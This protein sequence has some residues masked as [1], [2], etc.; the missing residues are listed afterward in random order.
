M[1]LIFRLPV[2]VLLLLPTLVPTTLVGAYGD[3][4]LVTE[5][6]RLTDAEHNSHQPVIVR[7]S[8][9]NVHVVYSSDRGGIF[10]LYYEMLDHNGTT[11]IER[12]AYYENPE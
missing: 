7:D 8:A 9:G 6:I 3:G 1:P 12:T 2:L 5:S 4:V 11:L 10:Q